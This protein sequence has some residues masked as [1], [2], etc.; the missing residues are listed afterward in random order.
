MHAKMLTLSEFFK[1]KYSEVRKQEFYGSS[2]SLKFF[3]LPHQ[4][5]ERQRP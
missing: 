2:R 1:L 4:T 5:C 3:P